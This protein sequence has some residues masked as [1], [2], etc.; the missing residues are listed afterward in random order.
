MY[1]SDPRQH[2]DIWLCSSVLWHEINICSEPDG[3]VRLEQVYCTEQIWKTIW[4]FKLELS[5]AHNMLKMGLFSKTKQ[6]MEMKVHK[7]KQGGSQARDRVYTDQTRW[8]ESPR[9]PGCVHQTPRGKSQ[10]QGSSQCDPA[11]LHSW[12]LSCQCWKK[13]TIMSW[14][15][16]TYAHSGRTSS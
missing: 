1:F 7:S 3:H 16:W 8:A 4:L 12:N 2:C 15:D 13:R 10:L 14:K 5:S 9:R 6:W 11:W